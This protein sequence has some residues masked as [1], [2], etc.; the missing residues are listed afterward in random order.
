MIISMLTIGRPYAQRK[1]GS[2]SR[3][4]VNIQKQMRPGM[5][6]EVNWCRTGYKAHLPSPSAPSP[7]WLPHTR[8]V[9]CIEPGRRFGARNVSQTSAPERA[10]QTHHLHHD[11][12]LEFPFLLTSVPQRAELLRNL[13]GS[14]GAPQNRKLA[15]NEGWSYHASTFHG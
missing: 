9:A 13:L 11:I 8:V 6:I 3:L 4:D 15:S 1:F 2:D 7:S 12:L 10:S 14:G 5:L